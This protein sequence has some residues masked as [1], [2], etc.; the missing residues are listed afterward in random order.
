MKNRTRNALISRRSFVERLGL[1][2]GA[3]LLAPIAST[4]LLEAKG[5]AQAVGRKRLGVFLIGN[6]IS[7]ACS[8]FV[9]PDLNGMMSANTAS[10]TWPAMAKSIQRFGDRVAFLDGLSNP[11]H[12]SQHSN[13]YGT[14]SGISAA[15]GA[16]SEYG[17]PPGGTTIDQYL[18]NKVGTKNRWKSVLAGT[19]DVGMFSS[20]Y[21]RREMHYT[22]PNKLFDAVF[23]DL[24]TD[25]N[26][27]NKGAIRK[28]VLMDSLRGDINKLQGAFSANERRK[29]DDY[30]LAIGEF[31]RRQMIGGVLSCKVPGAPT[32][33]Y[34]TPEDQMEATV[35][36]LSLALVCGV[37]DIVGFAIKTGMSHQYFGTYNR[38][39]VGTQFESAGGIAGYG[40]DPCSL[41]GPAMDLIH[42]FNL[43]L[44]ARMADSL[45]LV[46][47]PDGK[48]VFDNTVMMY[49]SDSAGGHHGP[50]KRWPVVLLGN[51]GGAL[52]L[53]GRYI[54]YKLQSGEAGSRP[55]VDLYSTFTHVMGAP[56]DDFGGGDV[57]TPQGPLAELMA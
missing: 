10:F 24:I 48:S 43:G 36:V 23:G 30:L 35:D 32:G 15:D 31:E 17:G 37:T 12:Q 41:Q 4:L 46:K 42:N 14:L 18:A 52:K 2:A 45:S 6:G 7:V 49:T 22:S 53:G 20:G 19:N 8:T 21:K 34:K 11:I 47:D 25:T 33:T 13:G 29:L 44:M 16:S 1:G 26:G 57:N 9:P 54:R 56:M 50:N 5:S 28:R 40:H 39:Q 3:T 55:L 27:V 51:A 38:I